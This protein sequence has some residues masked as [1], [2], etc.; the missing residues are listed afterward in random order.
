MS[1]DNLESTQAQAAPAPTDVTPAPALLS[2]C[3]RSIFDGS[4]LGV[5]EADLERRVHYA[6]PAALAMLGASGWKGLTLDDAFVRGEARTALEKELKERRRGILGNYRTLLRRLSDHQDILVDITGIPLVD[7]EGTV[8]GALGI[9]RSLEHERLESDLRQLTRNIGKPD[10]LLCAVAARL[11][12][13]LPFDVMIVSRYSLS[14][15]EAD[16]YFM[17]GGGLADVPKVWYRF[18]AAQRAWMEKTRSGVSDFGEVLA[19]PEW[20]QIRDEPMVQ[21]LL[22]LGVKKSLWRV[23]ERADKTAASISL[24]SRDPHAFD[25]ADQALFNRLPLDEAVLRALDLDQ[26]G[27]QDQKLELL[28]ALNRQT[29]VQGACRVLAQALVGMFGWSHVSVFR[30]DHSADLIRLVAGHWKDDIPGIAPAEFS[31]PITSGVLGRVV[32]TGVAQNVGDVSK[33]S[34]YRVGPNTGL[35]LSELAAPIHFESDPRVRFIINVDDDRANAFSDDDRA[36][37]QAM[38]GEVAGVM[39]RISQVYFLTQCFDTASDPILVTD[40]KLSIRTANPAA[41]VLLG[42]GDAGRVTGA[43]ADLFERPE[44]FAERMSHAGN[45]LGELAV[46]KLQGSETHLVPVYVTRQEFPEGLGGYVFVARDLRQI[47]RAV[48]MDFL[49]KAAYEVA[50]ETRTPLSLAMAQLERLAADSQSTQ[51]AVLDQ[52]LRRLARVK[53]AYTRLAMFNLQARPQRSDHLAID[54]RAELQALLGGL[55]EEEMTHVELHAPEPA[56][57]A[58]EGDHYQLAIVFES[59]LAA[60]MRA[61]PENDKV[62]IRVAWDQGAVYVRFLGK[63][64]PAKPGLTVG[65][66]LYEASADLRMADP[67][68]NDIM[69]DHGGRFSAQQAP[70]GRTEF[71][72][73]FPA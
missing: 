29:S 33:D 26:Q 59:L 73:Q 63:L 41:A 69:R 2:H 13:A 31:Q 52:A 30:V 17:Y 67:L 46:R 40:A 44:L 58:I 1:H 19:T 45:D 6:N 20:Q 43:I 65:R 70:G 4:P 57:P 54:V 21:Q 3:D 34:A 72:L 7:G 39:Q 56:P 8:V 15:E 37:L 9:F 27:V 68:L 22:E 25:A 35:V 32:E 23:I 49:E 53:H 61:R 47:R 64:P 18:T 5:I 50:I 38:A 51:L 36:M 66:L 62:T 42:L 60:L 28:R 11:K 55:T 12:E 10:E 16:T 14:A 48:E 71:S 24:M